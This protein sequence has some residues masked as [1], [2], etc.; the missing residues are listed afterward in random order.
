MK[1]NAHLIFLVVARFLLYFGIFSYRGGAKLCFSFWFVLFFV[2]FL[3]V[4]VV[5]VVVLAAFF[6][7]VVVVA[8]PPLLLPTGKPP[9]PPPGP[10]KPAKSKR[11]TKRNEKHRLA[12]PL[13]FSAHLKQKR[14]VAKKTMKINASH[15]A[16]GACPRWP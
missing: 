3:L 11:K 16:P 4:L 8:V 2:L 9:K 13:L 15:L 14:P 7:V 6:L 5:L 12:S 10:P 1:H